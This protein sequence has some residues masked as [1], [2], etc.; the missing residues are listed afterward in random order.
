MDFLLST[1][2]SA[3]IFFN[4]VFSFGFRP[5]TDMT[6][7]RQ[8]RYQDDETRISTHPFCW[9][10]AIFFCCSCWLASAAVSRK[11]FLNFDSP[12]VSPVVTTLS[13][14]FAPS[15]QQPGTAPTCVF[16]LRAGSEKP[17]TKWNFFSNQGKLSN[18]AL[19]AFDSIRTCSFIHSN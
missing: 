17:K 7:Y 13:F 3:N 10:S 15:R 6:Y 14:C 1:G 8:R 16:L 18:T 5:V 2:F 11:F 9:L 4:T 19:P 12:P